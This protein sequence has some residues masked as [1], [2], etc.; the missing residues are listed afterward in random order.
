MSGCE[1]VWDDP[2]VSWYELAGPQRLRAS[3]ISCIASNK[4]KQNDDPAMKK[5]IFKHAICNSITLHH[6]RM[7]SRLK[8]AC[9]VRGDIATLLEKVILVSLLS[10]GKMYFS[11]TQEEQALCDLVNVGICQL[12]L[13]LINMLGN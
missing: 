6:G 2:E 3:V 4:S 8:L 7:K 5:Q 12:V 9:Q 13:K 11:P 1:E 10:N